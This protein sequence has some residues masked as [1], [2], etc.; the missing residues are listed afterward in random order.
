MLTPYLGYDNVDL[1]ARYKASNNPAPQSPLDPKFFF[2]TAAQDTRN[3]AH[4]TACDSS[5]EMLNEDD[6]EDDEDEEADEVSCYDSFLSDH[7][8]DH[9]SQS[10]DS[11]SLGS[12]L[13]KTP[14]QKAS[15]LKQKELQNRMST[16]VE[17][18]TVV[19]PILAPKFYIQSD[20]RK[21]ATCTIPISSDVSDVQGFIDT[22]RRTI[23]LVFEYNSVFLE[24]GLIISGV[25]KHHPSYHTTNALVVEKTHL[26]PIKVFC[27]IFL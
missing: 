24:S 4:H 22:D 5:A 6:D 25:E 3:P 18:S 20:G 14:K 16:V 27:S 17:E 1:N 10:F 21:V 2:G 13:P 12:G 8:E 9:L 23:R 26:L 19:Y 7:S 11:C 15:P